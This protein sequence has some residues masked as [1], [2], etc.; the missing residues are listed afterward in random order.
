MP[1]DHAHD[2]DHDHHAAADG[3]DPLKPSCA[4]GKAGENAN[5]EEDARIIEADPA[6][7]SLSHA[8]ST[9]FFLLKLLWDGAVV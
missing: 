1:D 9:S 2:H 6:T 7:R 3:F 4:C 5:P 8:L